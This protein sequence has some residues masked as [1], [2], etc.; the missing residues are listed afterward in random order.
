MLGLLFVACIL[1]AIMMFA[2][3]IA[4]ARGKT[5]FALRYGFIWIQIVLFIAMIQYIMA[6]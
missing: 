4:Y 6:L 3:I 5:E 1:A 2:T